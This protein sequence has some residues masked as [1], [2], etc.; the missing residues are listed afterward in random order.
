MRIASLVDGWLLSI[1]AGS[2]MYACAQTRARAPAAPATKQPSSTASDAVPLPA[3][4]TLRYFTRGDQTV[5][6]VVTPDTHGAAGRLALNRDQTVAPKSAAQLK[7]VAQ[8]GKLVL[9][10][11]DRYASR[12]GPMSYC[13]A[14]HEEFLRVLTIAPRV[15]E[16]FQL[17]LQGCRSNSELAEQGVVW[18]PESSTLEIHWL[19]GPGA[20]EHNQSRAYRIDD[21]G[22]V[23]PVETP[24]R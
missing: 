6:E 13:Q 10:V 5:V 4:G 16:T 7:L 8:V 11:S 20:D 24:A 17:K 23:K 3:G 9:I 18:K 22:D 1:L 19:N 12:P 14:G 21:R 15:R 2:M